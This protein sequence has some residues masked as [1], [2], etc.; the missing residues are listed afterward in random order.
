MFPFGVG[1]PTYKLL[2]LLC[3]LDAPE[4][5]TFDQ[6]VE[7]LSNYISP[8]LSR[9][10]ARWKFNQRCQVGTESIAE[11]TTALKDLAKDCTYGTMRDELIRDRLVVGTKCD[12]I[13]SRLLEQKD[14]ANLATVL[15]LAIMLERAASSTS[16]LVTN[17]ESVSVQ[18]IATQETKTTSSRIIRFSC[19]G[20][21]VRSNCKYRDLVYNQCGKKG[22]LAKVC[23]SSL[24]KESTA[25]TPNYVAADVGE[26]TQSSASLFSVSSGKT[27]EPYKLDLKY[28]TCCPFSV[29]KIANIQNRLPLRKH[30]IYK[31]V[32]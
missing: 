6:L 15:D 11:F 26:S 30:L 23:R 20:N 16:T 12:H 9:F 18:K 14:D 32:A 7:S 8:T 28:C 31:I 2:S 13:K 3:S 19:R 4:K 24:N 27:L 1:L 17:Y 10:V 21:H 29:Q 25:P 22:H 5:K